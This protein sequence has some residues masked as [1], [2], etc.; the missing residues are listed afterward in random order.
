MPSAARTGSAAALIE[1]LQSN[2]ATGVH[3]LAAGGPGFVSW[4]RRVVHDDEASAA[5]PSTTTAHDVPSE[6]SRP[7]FTRP[8]LPPLARSAPSRGGVFVFERN[9][10][11]RMVRTST[12][13]PPR[14]FPIR[15][16]RFDHFVSG[17][18]SPNESRR[19][20]HEVLRRR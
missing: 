2:P 20:P 5:A 16:K 12:F 15:R 1:L 17:E 9:T 18:G 8:S 14:S 3:A 6:R 19:V 10:R 13:A 7:R 11:R 4:T